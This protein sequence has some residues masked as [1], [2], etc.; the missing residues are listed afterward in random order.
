MPCG[1]DPVLLVGKERFAREAD[2]TAPVEVVNQDE[3]TESLDVRQTLCVLGEQFNRPVRVRPK[4]TLDGRCVLGQEWRAV[5]PI[6]SIRTADKT[7]SP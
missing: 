5:T 3:M 7:S 1:E 2:L 4:G 6:G